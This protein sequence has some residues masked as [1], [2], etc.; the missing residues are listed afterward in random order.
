MSSDRRT[1]SIGMLVPFVRDA[2]TS[3]SFLRDFAGL[4]ES[5]GVESVWAVEHVV[6]AAHYEPNYPYAGDGRMPGAPGTIPIPDPLEVLTYLAAVSERLLLGTSVVVAPLHSA[7][8]LA[9]RA[10]TLDLLSEGRLR[11]GLGIGWQQEEYAAV[12]A[13]FDH[14]GRRLEECVQA[15]RALW[16]DDPATFEG[17]HVSFRDV[18]LTIRPTA[19]RVPI[20]L[21]GN[22][23]A[24]IRRAGRIADGWFPYTVGPDELAAGATLLRETATAAGRRAEDVEI[25][26]WPGSFDPARELDATWMRR[27]LDAGATRLVVRPHVTRPDDLPRLAEQIERFR[28]VVAEAS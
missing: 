27:Y 4:L 21:G 10:A 18:H 8:V 1:V 16:A 14:R 28:A 25:T 24:A 7:A 12:G 11:L 2:V 20:V 19:G 13:P 26:V 22:S 3:R 6:V 17:R 9:K 5:N 15:M 23:D